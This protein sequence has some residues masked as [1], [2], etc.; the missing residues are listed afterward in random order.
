MGG[1]VVAHQP[2]AVHREHHVQLLE[3]YVVDDLVVAALEEGGVDRR[4][5]LGP[6]ERQPGG[7]Q[8]GVLLRDAH[9]VVAV[10]QRLLQQVQAGA[11][12]S[13]RR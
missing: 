8:H 11:A 12:S 4:H 6:L 9:V 2:G 1:A 10:G 7:E 3:A 13:S 5:G